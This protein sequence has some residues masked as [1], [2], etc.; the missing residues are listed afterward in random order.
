M[1]ATP[2]AAEMADLADEVEMVGERKRGG[3]GGKVGGG[4]RGGGGGGGAGREVLIS[5]AL[6]K[7][8]RHAAEEEGLKLDSEGFARLDLVLQWPRLK[9]LKPTFEDI[10]T[11]VNDNAKQ[12]F[13][14]KPNPS[15][16]T[17][18]SPSS[19]N[20]S[21]WVIRANQGHSIAIDSAALLVPITLEAGN[22]PETVVHG[23]YFAFY[24]AIVE[25]GGLKK[26]GRN[27]VHFG[28]GLPEEKGGVV[29]GMRGDAELLIY[30]DLKRCLEEEPEMKWWMSENGVVLTEGDGNGVVGTRFWK[31]VVGRREGGV[32]WEDGVKVGELAESLRRRRAPQGKG[33]GDGGGGRGRGGWRGSGK[34]GRGGRGAARGERGTDGVSNE[35]GTETVTETVTPSNEA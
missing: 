13:S 34:S 2:S 26:M 7:L 24:D 8:L 17:P 11:A 23:T 12:R 27:H 15:L 35:T 5:K 22:V 16:S 28:T 33:R 14:M 32:L 31:K 29:S 21:D 30:V 4:R 9:S 10:R 18:P 1:D 25:S 6:S 3:R 20:P 19:E